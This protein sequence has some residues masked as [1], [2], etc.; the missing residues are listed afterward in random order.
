MDPAGGPT[1]YAAR[2]G[3]PVTGADVIESVAVT[4][5]GDM[6]FATLDLRSGTGAD[7]CLVTGPPTATSPGGGVVALSPPAGEATVTTVGLASLAHAAEPWGRRNLCLWLPERKPDETPPRIPIVFY[8]ATVA[9]KPPFG[10][11]VV[12][13][14]EVG[15]VGRS[16]ARVDVAYLTPGEGYEQLL[17]IVNRG[18]RAVQY[19]FDA[20]LPPAGVT[21]ALTPAAAAA[22]E[23]GLNTIA[24]GA[25][26]TLR[27]AETLDIAGPVEAPFTAATLWL[28]ANAD[29]ID[30]AL[31][32]TNLADGSTDT[33]VY[34]ALPSVRPED[35]R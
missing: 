13:S 28:N 15:V 10:E 24:P 19:V 18:L 21:V 23:S 14:G 8:A 31:V 1:V 2:G 32:R 6:T 22:A 33:V 11:T 30:V 12:R 4:I 20:F 5:E 16:G 7:R 34:P 25:M 35:R 9:V 3:R 27:V 17:V 29:Q 26:V